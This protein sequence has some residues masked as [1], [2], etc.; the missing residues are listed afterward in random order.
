MGGFFN[1]KNMAIS[2]RENLAAR[3]PFNTEPVLS[4]ARR[5]IKSEVPTVIPWESIWGSGIPEKVILTT[6]G[7]C[8][9]YQAAL[10]YPVT[11]EQNRGVDLWRDQ[12]RREL[13]NHLHRTPQSREVYR[14]LQQTHRIHLVDATETFREK[15][16]RFID[17]IMNLN[18]R[19]MNIF[20]KGGV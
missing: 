8:F 4:T 17:N 19:L 5:L 11:P 20:S 1:E 16:R 7:R 13:L 15:Y 18:G 12:T 6:A 9:A 10:E 2:I 14:S 3:N